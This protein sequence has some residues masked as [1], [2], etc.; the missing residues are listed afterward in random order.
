MTETE[1]T[2]PQRTRWG[3]QN[4]S[5]LFPNE[6]VIPINLP[7][8]ACPLSMIPLISAS[9]DSFLKMTT[10][11]LAFISSKSI[12]FTIRFTTPSFKATMHMVADGT[13]DDID[14]GLLDIDGTEDD[15]DYGS[16][17][18]YDIDEGKFDGL[19]DSD[20]TANGTDDGSS[21]SA[22][23]GINKGSPDGF[24]D[25][26]SLGVGVGIDEGGS[27]DDFKAGSSLGVNI[28]II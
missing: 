20:G 21:L 8:H 16:L 23:L 27:L 10:M 26:S 11:A 1:G 25:G 4:T 28:G 18:S 5:Y 7:S 6:A 17:D 14:K 22:K 24:K 13:E 3:H 19:L 2:H 15:I 9:L 12:A